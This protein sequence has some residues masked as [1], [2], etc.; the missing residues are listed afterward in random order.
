MPIENM[1]IQKARRPRGMSYPLRSSF[2]AE[3]LQKNG[4][5]LDTQLIYYPGGIFFDAHFWPPSPNVPYERLYVRAAAVPA[6]Q[7][8]GARQYIEGT[9]VPE[10][11]AWLQDI[12]SRAPNS[13]VRR[14]KHYFYREPPPV[15]RPA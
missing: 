12:I 6:A 9:V 13:P 11:I 14:E 4:I 10:L 2:I 7:A 1:H 8:R 5:T 15:L 3:A